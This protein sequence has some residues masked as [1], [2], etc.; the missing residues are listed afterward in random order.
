MV[1]NKSLFDAVAEV[2][3]EAR[4]RQATEA[5]AMAPETMP[6]LAMPG[7]GAEQPMAAPPP[8]AGGIEGLLAQL[9]A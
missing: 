5:E 1:E 8:G 4:E 2:D 6:G 9:G 3:Q 7:M